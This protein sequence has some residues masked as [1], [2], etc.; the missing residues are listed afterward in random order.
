MSASILIVEDDEAVQSLLSYNLEAEGFT[1]THTGLGEEVVP[2]I[3]GERP[4]LVLLD[5]MLPDIP[6]IDVCRMIRARPETRDTPVMMLTARGEEAERVRGLASGADDYMVKP[7][8]IQELIARIRTILRRADPTLVT[9]QLRI[10]D[11]MLDR[12]T[13][14]V[15]RRRRD[16]NR[17][18]DVHVGRLRKQLSRGREADP[19]RTVRGLGYAFDERYRPS[20]P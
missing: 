14:R 19:I 3:V 1:V 2:L 17:T 8:S 18:V 15:S 4:N 12:R 11:I 7:F 9:D 5:W 6:G 20:A 10:G 16:L 13:R